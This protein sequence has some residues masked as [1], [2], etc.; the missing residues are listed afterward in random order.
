MVTCTLDGQTVEVEPG[1]TILT[2]ARSIGIDIPTFCFH[3]RLSLSAS[4][5]MCLVKVEGRNKLE[6]A[7]ATAVAP[8][9]V[10]HTRSSDVVGTR[11]DMLEI[12]LANHPLD[13]PVCDKGG[14]CELQDTVYEYGKGRSRLRDP[15]RVFRTRDIELNKVIVFNANRCIQCQRCVRVCEEVVGDV[16]LG[17]VER[18]LDS[19]ITGVGNSLKDCS[20]CGNC[21]EVCPVGALMSIPY[22]YKARPWDL[23]KTETI[24]G[25]CGTGCS[26]TVETRDGV[27]KRVKSD[28]E[29][30]LNG[31][32]LC[33]KGRFGFDAIDGGKRIDQ[34]MVRKNGSLEPVNWDTAIQCIAAKA[35]EVKERNGH[36]QGQISPRQTNETA[37]MFQRLMRRVFGTQDIRSSGRFGGL[38]N[39]DTVTALARVVTR[40]MRRK[41]L[42]SMLDA[43]CIFLLGANITDENPVS[44]YL[45]RSAMKDPDKRLIIASSRPSGLDGIAQAS[46]RLV[47]GNEASLLSFLITQTPRDLGDQT[48]EFASTAHDILTGAADIALLIGSDFLR[49]SNA[50][51]CFGWIEQTVQYLRAQ[52]KTVDLQFLFDRPN[53]L[54]LWDMGCLA[55]IAPGWHSIQAPLNIRESPPDLRYVLG[56]DPLQC[57]VDDDTGPADTS[58][59]IIHAGY[60]NKATELADVVLPLAPY[61]EEKGTFTNNEGRVQCLCP[62]RSRKPDLISARQVFNLISRAMWQG[63]MPVK[64]DQVQDQITAEYPAFGQFGPATDNRQISPWPR[65]ALPLPPVVSHRPDEN[66]EKKTR[67]LITG[68]SL[69]Q[70]GQ[71]SLRSSTLASLDNGPYVELNP[72]AGSDLAFEGMTVTLSLAGGDFIAPLRVNRALDMKMVFVPE[73]FLMAKGKKFLSYVD[74]PR[75]VDVVLSGVNSPID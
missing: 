22:R 30:G 27:F 26:M 53:Q 65:P 15:K 5:R 34:P 36:L 57:D 48:I 60:F 11:Q 2:A 17:T 66:S 24:C 12:L 62:V 50:A 45:L 4:C 52:G 43:D 29:T 23:V 74:Y 32:L 28:P 6:P 7:C 49:S 58:F 38:G 71:L 19:E 75:V 3:E 39:A 9:M 13:C 21:I 47:P 64:V 61:G 40:L 8:D 44:G 1:T 10:V 56:A 73:S 33:A 31:E 54:G 46:L 68:D 72:G 69:F 55:G 51:D 25:M 42:Q 16:A 20:H 63:P 67:Y 59:L 70:S 14:E 41:P 18:G 37:F 35:C